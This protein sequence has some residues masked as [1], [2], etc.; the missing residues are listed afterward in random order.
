MKRSPSAL[1]L[2]TAAATFLLAACADD[3][4]GTAPASRPSAASLATTSQPRF[5]SNS[6]KYRDAGQKPAT[7]RSGSATLTALALLGSDGVTDLAVAAG[8]P[9]TLRKVQI[10]AFD[11]DALLWTRNDNG[12][13]GGSATYPLRGLKRGGRLQVQSN[14]GGVDGNRT[15][16]VT[17]DET[18]KLRP[19][20]SV[21]AIDAPPS[22]RVAQP[23][24]LAATIAELN[25]DVGARADCVLRVE[26]EVVD[27]ARGIWVDA[28]DAVDCAFTHS[29]PTAGTVHIS[30]AAEGVDP[31]DYLS[32]NNSR[33][34]TVIVVPNA[35]MGL[36]VFAYEHD[37][38][39]RKRRMR[40]QYRGANGFNRDDDVTT[41]RTYAA[42]QSLRVDGELSQP[43]HG[44]KS[45]FRVVEISDGNELR[46]FRF[47][48]LSPVDRCRYAFDSSFYGWLYYCVS[49]EGKTRFQFYRFG[50]IVTYHAT[51]TTTEWYDDEDPET[52][53]V[54][55]VWTQH[56][57]FVHP[58]GASLGFRVELSDGTSMHTREVA[59]TNFTRFSFSNVDMDVPESCF[60]R[61]GD[62]GESTTCITDWVSGSGRMVNQSFPAGS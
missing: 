45:W 60:T 13:S 57:G 32:G 43:V 7:G 17:V 29:F 34:A 54:D 25:G 33:S 62:W 30:V 14:I 59:A 55:R 20:L 16:V 40:F 9:G 38:L 11:G 44:P 24:V 36:N 26:G 47:A 22:V 12:P 21:Q 4:V 53:P 10:K 39:Y 37:E 61:S 48:P 2:S 1:L 58:W 46:T 42:Y 51:G 23:T 18:I 31:G 49:P 19:D 27:R 56:D 28:G 50:Q 15:G 5:V 3:P 8:A 41:E 35:S 6:V 52:Q